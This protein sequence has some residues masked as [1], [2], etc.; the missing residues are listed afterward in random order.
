[1]VCSAAGL[2]GHAVLKYSQQGEV[3]R[4]GV[5]F[6]NGPLEVICKQ[7]RPR[8]PRRLATP[9]RPP[10][11]RRNCNRALALLN[12][13]INTPLP[14][15][16]IERKTFRR[17]AWLVT[18][19]IP[20][21][22]DLDQIALQLLPRIDCRRSRKVKDTILHELVRLFARM[23]DGALTHR[24]MKASNIL[25]SNW[26]GQTGPPSVWIADLDGLKRHT[27]LSGRRPWQ[28]VI[29]LAASLLGHSAVTRGDCARFLWA[30]LASRGEPRETRRQRFRELALRANHYVRKSRQRKS[31]KLDGYDG[32]P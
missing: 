22:V 6:S 17:E 29:R 21:L 32:E 27:F 26:D 2:P 10:R 3:L 20:G 16:L 14:L 9:F 12:A 19:F 31:H 25:L 18:E 15:A 24:D 13:G 5:E 8:G 23:D 30:Y 11:E 28:P 7:S 1:L 4:A